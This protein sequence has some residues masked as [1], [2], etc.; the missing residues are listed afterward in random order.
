VDTALLGGP[1]PD[2]AAI[3]IRI[4]S[5]EA[6]NDLLALAQAGRLY[7][8]HAPGI[9]DLD[10][11]VLPCGVSP[12]SMPMSSA[13]QVLRLPRTSVQAGGSHR[14]ATGRASPHRGG[15][16]R[17]VSAKSRDRSAVEDFLGAVP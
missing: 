8:T 13:G 6:A 9:I 3:R 7:P 17:T 16:R 15:S 11:P 1:V 4:R 2:P 5:Q 10:D 12:G 14:A